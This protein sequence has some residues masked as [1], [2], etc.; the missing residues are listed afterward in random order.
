MLRELAFGCAE[1]ARALGG[2]PGYPRERETGPLVP[3]G[4]D[5]DARRGAPRGIVL[6]RAS[7]PA[8]QARR[9]PRADGREVRVL[10]RAQGFSAGPQRLAWDGRDGEGREAGAG[11]YFVRMRTPMARCY[12]QASRKQVVCLVWRHT[13]PSAEVHAFLTVRHLT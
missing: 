12:F 9:P 4:M 13:R 10:A 7:W 5:A 11:V 8:L 1:S 6:V 3:F 2:I